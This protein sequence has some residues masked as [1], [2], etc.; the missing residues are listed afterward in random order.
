MSAIDRAVPYAGAL[1]ATTD[2]G[3]SRILVD[4]LHSF[5]RLPQ[6]AGAL[7]HNLPGGERITRL[8][9][10]PLSNVI[11]VHANTLRQNAHHSFYREV[12]LIAPES[13]HRAARWVVR[14]DGFGLNVHVGHAI[15]TAGVTRRAQQTLAAGTCIT[16]GIAHDAGAHGEQ[17]A[18]G[19]GSDCVMQNH[20]MA[21]DV[22]LRGLFS[23]E[24]SLHRPLQ[25]ICCQ[26]CLRLDGKFVFGA[27][28]A[29]AGS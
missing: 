23:R 17:M 11:T 9:N 26:C 29:A 10:V 1:D 14:I 13:P 3:I 15:R 12:R 18:L 24:N 5:E 25:Q 4:V 16:A 8:K 6:A 19:I 2:P 20:R 27:E 22:M 21:F 28:R 7:S